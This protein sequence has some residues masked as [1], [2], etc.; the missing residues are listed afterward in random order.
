MAV[1]WGDQDALGHVNNIVYFQ[2][3]ESARLQWYERLG[4]GP[5][6]NGSEGMVIVDNHAQYLK[7]V[8]YPSTITIYMAAHSPGRSS[9]VSTY[10]LCVGEDLYTQ[11]SAKVVWVDR[12]A[13]KSMPLPE[14]VRKLLS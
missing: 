5:L 12:V 6:A 10:H 8:V 14:S 11:G 4:H 3:F 1:R 9:F 2:Y 13:G 7:S